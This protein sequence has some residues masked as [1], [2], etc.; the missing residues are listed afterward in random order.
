M[1]A[2]RRL[3][4]ETANAEAEQTAEHRQHEVFGEQLP[5]QERRRRAERGADAH[6]ALALH[7]PRQR[8]IGD[9]GARDDEDEHRR[10][11]QNDERRLRLRRELV[12]PRR[13]DD[14]EAARFRIGLG[15]VLV[16]RRG[17]LPQLRLRARRA[18]R[19]ARAARTRSSSDAAARSASTSSCSDR[20]R[21][22]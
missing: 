21:R 12:L 15:M 18:S 7:E 8:E 3:R 1:Y 4:P 14:V 16:E 13:D 19:P 6:L 2:I 20:W 5:P 17:D 9:V 22:S 11:E 10:D